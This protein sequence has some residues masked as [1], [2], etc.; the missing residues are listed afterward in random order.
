[1]IARS[2]SIE[3]QA[4][5]RDFLRLIKPISVGIQVLGLL[6]W[7]AAWGLADPGYRYVSWHLVL[8]A[9]L[10]M[11]SIAGCCLTRW[12]SFFSIITLWLLSLAFSMLMAES[13]DRL[14][15]ALSISVIISLVGAP[16]FSRL[17]VS[18]MA[19]VG[20]W[21]IIGRGEW[22]GTPHGL[23]AGWTCLMPS[24]AITL[25]LLMQVIFTKL[26]R[27]GLSLRQELEQLAYKDV[28]TGMSN[29]RKLLA[30]IQSLHE[31]GKLDDGCFLMVDVDDF[32]RIN[33]DFGHATG[34]IALQRIG[35]VL[36]DIAGENAFGRLGGEEFGIMLTGGGLEHAQLVA[37]RILAEVQAIRIRDRTITVSVGISGLGEQRVPSELIREADVALYEAKRLGKDRFV[38][39]GGS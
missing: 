37:A 24:A 8:I 18:A 32:K 11:L 1:M 35:A 4:R 31:Q 10:V 13:P 7:C 20:G 34:D 21:L 14:V 36:R 17:S 19:S 27:E 30:D 26:H 6:F 9:C 25:G 3:E 12:L 22:I 38:L 5:L 23:D 39:H 16:L 28:L 33:D 2:P 15:W 29:R